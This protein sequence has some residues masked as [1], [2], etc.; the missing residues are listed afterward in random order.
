MKYIISIMFILCLLTGCND[1][2]VYQEQTLNKVSI[3]INDI[4][5]TGAT[6][7]IKDTNEKPYIYG[8]W[9]EIEKEVDNSWEKLEVKNEASF[10]DMGYNVDSNNIVEFEM[11]WEDYYGSLEPGNYRIVKKV[12]DT[13]LYTYFKIQNK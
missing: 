7:S 4:T 9:Y 6:I 3:S 5:S 11:N 12:N 13:Y 8:S 10:T 2:K 1:N